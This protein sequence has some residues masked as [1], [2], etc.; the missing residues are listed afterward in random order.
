MKK[1]LFCFL[2]IC[3]LIISFF[4]TFKNISSFS[5]KEE[6]FVSDKPFL[7]VIK[8]LATKKSFEEIIEQNDAV[9]EEK[10]WDYLDISIP[11][12]VL[13]IREYELN[14]KMNFSILKKDLDL[15][16]LRLFFEQ[17]IHLDKK[18]L[19]IKIDLLKEHK[20]VIIY[21]KTVEIV[22]LDEKSSKIF[23]KSEIK[24]KK[25]IPFFYENYMNKKVEK[26][27]KKDILELKNNLKKIIN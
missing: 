24:I 10:T 1:M 2:L 19:N 18:S 3:F 9:L 27:N 15:G 8:N 5:S 16:E 7:V 20:N 25:F 4:L 13:K 6:S 21:N 14:G 12:R 11:K 17:L 23:I 26:N 22:P